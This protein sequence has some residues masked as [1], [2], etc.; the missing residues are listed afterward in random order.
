MKRA[1]LQPISQNKRKKD[2]EMLLLLYINKMH[3]PDEMNT[4]LFRQRSLVGYNPWYHK[5]SDRTGHIRQR[6]PVKVHMLNSYPQ[7]VALFGDRVFK[8]IS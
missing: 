7:K 4:F 3:N 5:E 8:E 1:K 6:H 2:C